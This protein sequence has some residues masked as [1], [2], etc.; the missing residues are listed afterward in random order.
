MRSAQ[1]FIDVVTAGLVGTFLL[2]VSMTRIV[3]MM[4]GRRFLNLW[5][6]GTLAL[7]LAEDVF[8]VVVETHISL[9]FTVWH[10]FILLA[11]SVACISIAIESSVADQWN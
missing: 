5:L 1:R 8:L 9:V 3:S 6:N 7:T 11:F 4:L 10:I 2:A